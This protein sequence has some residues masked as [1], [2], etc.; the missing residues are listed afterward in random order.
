MKDLGKG[1]GTAGIW[2][3]VGIVSFSPACGSE[4]IG[5][6]AMCAF[7]ATGALWFF[8]SLSD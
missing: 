1:I 4:S 8:A 3:G 5:I 7:F 2:I 6:V